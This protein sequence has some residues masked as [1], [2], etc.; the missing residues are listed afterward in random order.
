MRS[1][2]R[3]QVELLRRQLHAPSGDVDLSGACVDDEIPVVDDAVLDA[4]TGA[5]QHRAHTRHQLSGREGLHDIVVG[6]E[7]QTQH[8]IDLVGSGRQQDDRHL[9]AG[10]KLG[11]KIESRGTG[12][13]DVEHHQIRRRPL[14]HDFRLVGIRRLVHPEPFPLQVGGNDL[15]NPRLVVDH[16]D[17]VGSDGHHLIVWRR[18]SQATVATDGFATV[19]VRSVRRPYTRRMP[20]PIVV[21]DAVSVRFGPTPVLAGLDLRV[22]PGTVVGVAGPNGAGKTTLLGVVATLVPLAAGRGTV[23]GAALGSPEARLVRPRIGWSGHEPAL[24][25][26]L[27][28]QENLH[29]VA[30]LAGLAR[31]EAD[32][33]LRRVGLGAAGHRRASESSNGMRRRVDLA[34]LLMRRPQ[35]LLLDEAHAGLDDDADAIIDV[36]IGMTRRQGGAV[37]MVSHDA[38]RLRADADVVIPLGD[39]SP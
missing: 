26:H 2:V 13:H 16:Q 19:S 22:D 27:T 4:R 18:S 29:L 30:D 23:L 37:V 32:E 28:L 12:K 11:E 17:A 20:D 1:H 39:L 35:L 14:Q 7:F 36:L 21:L 24:Y 10:T 8:P 15:A 5:S 38:R 34:S 31:Q 9:R 33:A 25:D 3:Q 6:A